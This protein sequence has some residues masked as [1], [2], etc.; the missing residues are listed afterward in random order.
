MLKNYTDIKYANKTFTSIQ[1]A[2]QFNKEKVKYDVEEAVMLALAASCDN[3]FYQE[4]ATIYR[5]DLENDYV[6]ERIDSSQFRALYAQEFALKLNADI[7]LLPGESKIQVRVFVS[8]VNYDLKQW[9]EQILTKF[10]SYFVD[11]FISDLTDKFRK[12]ESVSYPL[13]YRENSNSRCT[14]TDPWIEL[15]LKY[16]DEVDDLVS[17]TFMN[18]YNID[19][20]ITKD[21]IVFAIADNIPLKYLVIEN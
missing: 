12:Y 19:M 3:K 5:T 11:H 14:K 17:L 4:T 9:K 15:C 16:T 13:H 10:A 1:E 18:D 20:C 7:F 2:V 6:R 21:E 8:E